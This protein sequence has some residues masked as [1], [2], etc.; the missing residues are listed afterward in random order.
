MVILDEFDNLEHLGIKN[1]FLSFGKVIMVQKDT[2]Y[3]VSSSRN[4][5][6]KKII[7]EKLSLLFGNF[8][9][10]KVSNFD[11]K[12]SRE[13][14][15]YKICWLD[16]SRS[17]EKIPHSVYGRQPVLL[18]QDIFQGQGDSHRAAVHLYRRRDSS[19]G[20]TRAL[21]ITPTA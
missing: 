11:I 7:S 16:I 8:E 21:S 13:I 17:P 15:R 4:E 19:A 3:I 5:A 9:V 18:E 12:T 10:V 20:Y 14:Y 1:P 6:I 2:M